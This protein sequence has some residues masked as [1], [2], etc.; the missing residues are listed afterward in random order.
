MFGKLKIFK[1][2]GFVDKLLK[3]IPGDKTK[4]ILGAAFIIVS[5]L[6]GFVNDL[7]PVLPDHASI[8]LI[9]LY[10]SQALDIIEQISNILGYSFASIGLSHKV[11]KKY[12]PEDYAITILEG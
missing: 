4:T 8:D 9:L 11:V 6:I 12:S 1:L 5:A 3:K 2:I 7:L 10:L